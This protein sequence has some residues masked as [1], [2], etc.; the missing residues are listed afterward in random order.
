MINKVILVGR[1]TRDPELKYT[2]N[3]IA[4]VQF[5]L[6]VNRPFVNRDGNRD[7]DFINCTAW[8]GQAENLS[9][10]IR[11]GALLG[12]E[13]SLQVNSF[14]DSQGMR[15]ISTTVVCD[16]V[17]FLEPRGTRE[18]GEQYHDFAQT[19]PTKTSG[20]MSYE[21][22]YNYWTSQSESL[23]DPFSRINR[24]NDV[25]PS[26]FEKKTPKQED[27]KPF[28]DVGDYDISNDDLPF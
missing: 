26:D 5:T 25:R 1:I 15:R 11:K 12:V 18:Q 24:V 2:P 28:D 23:E 6:A 3:G 8:R 4:Y 27:K 10:Y 20:P 14:D 7:T 19:P 16:T 21:P 9:R 17:S 13:G 22:D